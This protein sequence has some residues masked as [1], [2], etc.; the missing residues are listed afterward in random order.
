VGFRLGNRR[1]A[2]LGEFF[3]EAAVRGRAARRALQDEFVRLLAADG[4]GPAPDL[5]A[6][7][8][9]SGTCTVAVCLSLALTLPAYSPRLLTVLLTAAGFAPA[10]LVDLRPRA[11]LLAL[12]LA[13]V[14]A[15]LM[16]VMWAAAWRPADAAFAAGLVRV[17][18]WGWAGAVAGALAGHALRRADRRD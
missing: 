9:L 16:G 3:A 18:L 1:F 17:L 6:A 12:G 2:S 14:P 8:L 15:A 7:A 5:K 11:A 10:F 4:A 13:L